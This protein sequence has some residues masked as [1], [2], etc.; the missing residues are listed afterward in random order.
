MG[1]DS[2]QAG[3]TL[4]TVGTYAAAGA[5]V[6]TAVPVIGTAVGAVGGAVV[7]GLVSIFT[8][9]PEAQHH[10]ASI[11]GRSI[12]ARQI[13]EKIHNGDT[14]SLDAGAKA[15]A[16]LKDVHAD[17]AKLIQQINDMMDSA[18]KGPAA[19]Q[20]QAGAHPLGIWLQDSAA[21]LGRSSTYLGDQATA[22]HT[23]KSKVQEIA[24]KPPEGGFLDGMNPLSDTDSQIEKYNQQGQANVEA[25]NNY[26]QASMTNAGQLPQYSAWQ[27]N[28]FSDGGGAGG[29]PS[30][31]GAGGGVPGAGGMPGG[32]APAHAGDLPRFSS[33]HPAAT[34]PHTAAPAGYSPAGGSGAYIPPAWDGTSATGYTPPSAGGSGPGGGAGGFGP[35]GSGSGAGGAGAGGAGV[36]GIGGAFGPG[37]GVGATNGTGAGPGAA[38]AGRGGGRAGLTGAGT[39]GT[40]GMGGRGGHGRGEEDEE[41]QNKYMVGDD[42]NELFGT[43]ELT[44]PPVIGE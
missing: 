11:G 25:F 9:G 34:L 36:A 33:T 8:G 39:P 28:V 3:R 5:M 26:Y 21:N 37:S 32:A 31:A 30:G 18:W 10:E 12:D 41:H 43:D 38:G 14:T 16:A 27:G 1:N 22:F 44:A 24:A 40:P 42:P 35:G 7:G 23:V 15:A 17:R 13:W 20:V 6:G 29:V 19:G 2:Y 4:T